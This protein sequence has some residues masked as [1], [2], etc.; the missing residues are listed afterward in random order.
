MSKL[1][2]V[3]EESHIEWYKEGGEEGEEGSPEDPA[4]I[5]AQYD[6]DGYKQ[7]EEE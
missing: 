4:P 5:E 7:A 1:K 3:T 6:D 2:L